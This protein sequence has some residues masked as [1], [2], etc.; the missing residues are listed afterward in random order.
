MQ[1]ELRAA[2]ALRRA[3]LCTAL[4][5]GCGSRASPSAADGSGDGEQDTELRLPRIPD[6]A[7]LARMTSTQYANAIRD[8]FAPLELIPPAL[9]VEIK[10]AGGFENNVALQTATATRVEAHHRAALEVSRQVIAQIDPLLPCERGERACGHAYLLSLAERAWRRPLSED[11]RGS[12]LADF[13]QWMDDHGFDVA[14]ELS[15][16]LVLQAPELLYVPRFSQEPR[17]ADDRAVYGEPL[18][19]WA[20]ASR[21]A[22]FL[23][24]SLPDEELLERARTDALLERDVVVEQAWRMLG[25]WRARQAVA[26]MHRQLLSFDAVGSS[27]LDLEHYDEAFAVLGFDEALDADYFYH[28]DYLPQLRFE[29]EV[30]VAQHVFEG[31][32]TLQALLT[33]RRVWTTSDVAALAYGVEIPAGVAGVRWAGVNRSGLLSDGFT[34]PVF[35]EDYVP[36][37]LPADERAGLLTLASLQSAN[38]GPQ[39]PSPVDRGMLVLDRLLCVSLLPPGDVPPLEHSTAGQEPRTNR[40]KYEI[41]AQSPACAG[42]HEQIDGIGLTFEHYDSLGRFRE[43]D[44]E[45]RVDATGQLAGTDQDGPVADAVELS[46]R[47]SQSRTVHDCYVRQWYRYAFGREA[48][49]DDQPVLEALQEGFWASGGRIPELVVNIAASHAFRHRRIER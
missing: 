20:L 16:Q 35:V 22:L 46:T 9:P 36:I 47:L 27:G 49:A 11:D 1:H 39:Q 25:D 19:S 34:E 17:S 26:E 13:D 8:L 38:A 6:S 48:T 43:Y 15:I 30:F 29:P 12:L 23:W 7:P 18:T 40:E 31:E 37:D 42:C 28:F 44:G 45:Y 32:G 41:H 10:A 2:V 5:A 24:G 21:L 3:T 4:I 33:S 14:L